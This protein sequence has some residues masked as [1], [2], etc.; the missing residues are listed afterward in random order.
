MCDWLYGVFQGQPALAVTSIISGLALTI[1]AFTLGWRI[2]DGRHRKKIEVDKELAE[3]LKV[4]LERA[5]NAIAPRNKERDMPE[6]DVVSWNTA[7]RLIARYWKM[8]KGLKTAIYMDRCDGHEDYWRHQFYL[9][10]KKIENK[11]FFVTTHFIE[12]HSE[13]IDTTS[14]SIVYA[15]SQ[16][17]GKDRID[18]YSLEDLIVKYRLFS[19]E[20]RF[21]KQLVEERRPVVAEK[22]KERLSKLSPGDD[23]PCS[24]ATSGN[25]DREYQ[26]S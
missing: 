25:A 14:A 7:A 19:Y 9:L 24:T 10:L 3:E 4:S 26:R 5:F 12:S 6:N 2:W 22:A 13:Y 23:Q 8:Q 16:W 21:F 1:S 17:K 11:S 18:D 20:C 15:F